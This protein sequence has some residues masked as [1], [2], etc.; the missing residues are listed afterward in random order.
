VKPTLDLLRLPVHIHE[1]D[2]MKLIRTVA[3]LK[4]MKGLALAALS[5]ALAAPSAMAQPVVEGAPLAQ[6]PPNRDRNGKKAARAGRKGG[7]LNPAAKAK[8]EERE[9]AM[10]AAVA[11]RALTDEEKQQVREAATA[12]EA[13]VRAAREAYITELAASL[14]MEPDEVRLKLAQAMAAAR[15]ARGGA[16]GA[17]AAGAAG[18]GAGAGGNAAARAARR[19]ARRNRANGG[20][21]APAAAPAA[22][23]GMNAQQ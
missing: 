15:G 21:G 17:G 6:N 12:R 23:A 9:M 4:L 13:A 5:L 18:A 19:A 2:D 16:A 10:A 1:E 11:G 22:G 7:A 3:P 20:N 14:K 8:M